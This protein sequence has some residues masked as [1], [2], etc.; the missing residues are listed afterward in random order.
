MFRIS[1]DPRFEAEVKVTL[2]GGGEG[3]FRARFR[4]MEVSRIEALD[5][6]KAADVR[7]FLESVLVG[8][9]GI[10]DST[11]EPVLWG[12]ELK[13]ELIDWPHVRAALARAYFQG[14]EAASE[15]N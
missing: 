6:G 1:A 4:V 15:G 11:G 13:R 9:E 10:E 2:P 3:T 12:E 5:L 7:A 8:A 14:F